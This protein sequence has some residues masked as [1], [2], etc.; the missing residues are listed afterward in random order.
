MVRCGR[1]LLAAA[2][3]TLLAAPGARAETA[4]I[5]VAANFAGPAERL[6]QRFAEQTD[7]QIRISTGSTGTLAAQIRNGAPFMLLLSAD[8][9][10]PV[11]LEADGL[12]VAGTRFT[13]A[14][15]RL[16][17]WGPDSGRSLADPA[18]AL[19]DPSLAH[20]AIANPA[21]APYG[22]AAMQVLKALGLWDR[23]QP[24]L[25][26]GEDIS[27]TLQFVASGNAELGFVALSQVLERGGSRW[28]VP[29]D[30]HAPI[31]QQAVLLLPGKENA[32]AT[33]FLEFLRSAAAGEIIAAAGYGLEGP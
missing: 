16:V 14:V 29:S 11:Q 4:L 6:A 22:E 21:L 15:G 2:L 10:R 19:T 20:L 5:A 24:K 13:Y 28:E 25:V 3:L 8:A 12:T 23:L 30:L 27:Q 32:A 17:L 9:A 18:V 7:H 33:G 1:G 26:R 31:R